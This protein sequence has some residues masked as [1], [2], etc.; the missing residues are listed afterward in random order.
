V[1]GAGY[2]TAFVQAYFQPPVVRELQ[3]VTEDVGHLAKWWQN[4]LLRIFLVFIL[5]TIGSAIGTYLGAYQIISN[6]F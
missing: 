5:T 2:V 1:I 6:I 4:K 3:S